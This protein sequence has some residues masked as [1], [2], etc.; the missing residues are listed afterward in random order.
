MVKKKKKAGKKK[1]AKKKTA[2]KKKAGAKKKASA[3]KAAKSVKKK[4]RKTAKPKARKKA[5]KSSA[6]S[7]P[8]AKSPA[9]SKKLR[10]IRELRPKLD[11]MVLKI[12]DKLLKN[13]GDLLK[14]IRSSQA[15]E[16]EA[17]EVT[18]SN[19]IDLASSLEGREMLFQLSSR[20][21]NELRL[22]EDALYKIEKGTYGNCESCSKKITLKRL[23]ILPLTNLCIDCQESMES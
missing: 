5:K 4:V 19:E 15:V 23:Q 17:G 12:R 3:K 16:R 1:T 2:V 22:I 21:R 6:K 11:P 18:F 10:V 9:V 20:D 7:S 8:R 13:R 14:L